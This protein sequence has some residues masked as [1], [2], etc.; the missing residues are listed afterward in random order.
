MPPDQPLL[1]IR[2]IECRHGDQ[3]VVHGLSAWVESDTIACLLGPSGCGKTTVLRAIAGFEPVHHGHIAIKGRIVSSPGHM[4]APDKRRLGMVAQDYALFPH[5]TIQDNVAF[6]LRRMPAA[7]QRRIVDRFLGVVGLH[8]VQHR[9][10]H[11]LSGGQQ[12][13]VAL[14]RALAVGPDLLLLDEPFSS[15][16]VELRERLGAEVRAILKEQRIT[17]LMV[18]HDQ[19]EAFALGDVVGIMKEGEIVQWDTPFNLYHQ[20]ANRF[21]AG[22]IG[23]GVFVR[24]ELLSPDTAQTEVGPIQGGRSY[25]WEPGIEVDVLLRPDDII[26]DPESELRGEIV[27]EAFKGADILYTLRLPSG[28]ELLSLFPSHQ[29][30]RV[31]EVVG[32]RVAADH[33]VAFRRDQGI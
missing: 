2:D 5:L 28:A 19:Q 17:T 13:R 14:A 4:V 15:L 1:E 6:G 3:V 23:H 10:P 9:Y 11:E 33:L 24:G 12:Q 31:G 21:V 26:P 25:P 30:H 22:F 29:R 18:T 7:D 16:D 20:P 32:V 8:G 27:K